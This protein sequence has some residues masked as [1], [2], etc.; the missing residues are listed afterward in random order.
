[1]GDRKGQTA[2]DVRVG[3]EFAP[4]GPADL[5]R[6]ARGG[7]VVIRLMAMLAKERGSL[8]INGGYVL[9]DSEIHD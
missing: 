9:M 7:G 5:V 1:M 4:T 8:G 2:E 6:W 3:P